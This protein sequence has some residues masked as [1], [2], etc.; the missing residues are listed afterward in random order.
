MTAPG[1][2]YTYTR[3]LWGFASKAFV[4]LTYGSLIVFIILPLSGVSGE[5]RRITEYGSHHGLSHIS[6]T[7]IIQDSYGFLWIGTQD[8]LNRFDGY[9]FVVYR[10]QPSDP[11]SLSGSQ[12]QSV[13]EDHD[14]N[15]WVGTRD[16]LNKF[17]R[18][19][20]NFEVFRHDPGIQGS[21]SSNNILYIYQDRDGIIWLKTDSGID[22][23]DPELGIFSHYPHYH[24]PFNHLSET[25]YACI[26]ED[27]MA[28]LWVGSGYGLFLFTRETGE[29]TRYSHDPAD[30]GSI[31]NDK[32]HFIH[33]SSLGYLLIGTANGLNIYDMEKGIF[34]PFFQDDAS[35]NQGMA[36]SIFTLAEVQ[37]GTLLA[38]TGSG[39]YS[40]TPVEGFSAFMK[41]VPSTPF[42]D[43]GISSLL[44][45]HSGNLWIGTFGGLFM[46]DAKGNFATYRIRDYLPGSPAA[47]AFIASVFSPGAGQLWLGTWGG[48]LYTLDRNT[49]Y[50]RHYSCSADQRERVIADDFVHV[51]FRDSRG[52]VILGTGNGLNIFNEK[53]N[54]FESF[55]PS[56]GNA[57]CLV[58]AGNRVYSIFE[59]SHRVIWVGTRHGLHAFDGNGITSYYHDHLNGSGLPSSQV[60]DI[61]ECSEGYI[62]IATSNGL[63]RFNRNSGDFKNYARD[64]EMG[65]FSLS[66]NELTSL[67]EDSSGNLWI[68]SVAGLNRFF[69]STESFVVYT[70]K[71]G[72]P[73]N[74]IHSIIEDKNGHLWLSTNRGISRFSPASLD[75]SN[76]DIADGLQSYGFNPGAGYKSENGEIFFGGVAGVNAF[77]PDSLEKN[78]AFPPVVITLFQAFSPAG[79]RIINVFGEQEI[80]LR[81]DENSI[82]IEFAAL[83]FT[84]PGKNRYSYR[85][86]GLGDNR[87]DGGNQRRA[88]FS[89]IPPGTYTFRVK[90]S[91]ND[92]IWNE[93]GAAIKFIIRTPWW[94]SVY[95]WLIY[96]IVASVIIYLVILFSTSRLRNANILLRERE[97]ASEEIT[98][99]K[100]ELALKNTNITDSINYARRIQ[101]AMMPES[102]HFSK[103]FPDSFVYYKSKDIV[104]GD[105]YWVNEIDDKIFFAVVDCTGHG[106]AG[107]FMSIIGYELLR[108]IINIK[109]VSRP[110]DILNMLNDDFSVIFEQGGDRDF[111]FRDGMDIGFCV[112]DRKNARLEFAG[113]FSPLYIVRNNSIIEI[114]GNRFSVGLMEDLIGEKFENYSMDL[115]KEDM[116]YLFSDGYPD[117]FGG[118]SGKKFKYRRF[119]HLLLTIHTLPASRQMELLDQSI[120]Q[121]MGEH[122]Q[123]DDILI[124]GVRPGIGAGQD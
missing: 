49:G 6:V 40:F 117:Q 123:V 27:N 13:M 109:G 99:Q 37:Q 14:G 87:E 112:I 121:W 111:S 7:S 64:P 118:E 41:G 81:H 42:S 84:R 48:G 100:E 80:V 83:D 26:Y 44:E 36:N 30:P 34:N 98:R 9:E 82:S 106:V 79:S 62:W 92:G 66:H 108:N 74:L 73:N 3:L 52:R 78:P 20:N 2:L 65:R 12:I 51:I 116:I 67:L 114:K 19:R 22:R 101:L 91:N 1:I 119:R 94:Q 97:L 46:V 21:I 32:V 104:S 43:L 28:R 85:L 54:M 56:A 72:L 8:G 29:F 124:L 115:M 60:N 113:A 11:H 77:F 107:A 63:S 102:R 90:G 15:I 31:S 95:A 71:E 23:F 38:G 5:R 76:F 45:D 59:D 70:E 122:E 25:G 35:G 10:H 96:F 61:I 53:M 4:R 89:R 57:D 50:M 120:I 47:A 103:L 68:G 75:I 33:E 105:F 16:G 86:E 24:D 17:I 58:F 55:C 39:L 110:A 18:S 69:R 93:E 88:G